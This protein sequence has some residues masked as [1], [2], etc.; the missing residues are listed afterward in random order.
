MP[1]PISSI[2]KL[3]Q[4]V[5]W[6]A[7]GSLFILTFGLHWGT[8]HGW[9]RWDDPQ[10]LLFASRHGIWETF[11]GRDCYQQLSVASLT[12]WLAVSYKIDLV[13]F[14]LTPR[15]FYLHQL[16]V[17]W[18]GGVGLYILLRTA[19]SSAGWSLAGSGLFLISAP[20]KFIAE[21][22]MT[23]HYGEGLVF[24]IIAL[25]VY[26]HALKQ[27]RLVFTLA[28]TV[29][30]TLAMT[31][32]EVFVPLV[33]VL[34]FFP[35]FCWRQHWRHLIPMLVVAAGYVL[36]RR[37][38]LGEFLGGPV[39]VSAGIEPGVVVASLAQI[40]AILLGNSMVG[41][42]AAGVFGGML[43]WFLAR[44]KH[45]IGL[46]IM[47]AA[48][49]IGPLVPLTVSPGLQVADRYFLVPWFGVC[50]LVVI[51]VH[52]LA[53]SGRGQWLAITGFLILTGLTGLQTL[54]AHQMLTPLITEIETQQRFFW[55]STSDRI[56]W[57]SSTVLVSF[58]NLNG[59]AK[60]KTEG[61][62]WP[63]GATIVS[64]EYDLS[65]LDLAGRTVW[66]YDPTTGSMRDITADIP[67]RINLW[68][69]QV[70]ADKPL[71]VS[72]TYTNNRFAWSFGPYQKGQYH[73]ILT[74]HGESGTI[75]LPPTGIRKARL[76][77]F[78]CVVRYDSPDGWITYSSQLECAPQSGKLNWNRSFP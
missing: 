39:A 68:K 73:L 21:Q 38:M 36:W 41:P 16:C 46:V 8:L 5:D 34:P 32:K 29:A 55:D 31:A 27:D 71:F 19:I 17:V 57:P 65:R 12:P 45:L 76:E 66:T 70:F 69:Q 23:R 33:I 25:L 61:H 24:L 3:I 74:G 7:V 44:N 52:D 51:V 28:A 35:G 58:W 4:P 10:H 63:A 9:W 72:F 26:W 37:A 59:L 67:G 1:L 60:L 20:V 15:W 13:L 42:C 40:P 56:M 18:A 50:W 62:L 2:Q 64:D 11:A 14:G 78:S 54:A 22:L 6:V 47:A 48:G 77:P 43:I 49:L 30:Y 53:V 75:P